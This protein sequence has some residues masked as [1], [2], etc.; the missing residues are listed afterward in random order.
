MTRECV[1]VCVCVRV[2]VIVYALT[3]MYSCEGT[4]YMYDFKV[5]HVL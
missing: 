1:R 2:F 5:V 3:G 4:H